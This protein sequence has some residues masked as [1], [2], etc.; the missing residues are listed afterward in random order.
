MN[1]IPAYYQEFCEKIAVDVRWVQAF[2]TSPEYVSFKIPK[3]RGGYRT[4]LKPNAQLLQVQKRLVKYLTSFYKPPQAVHGFVAE[5]NIVSNASA[6]LGCRVLLNIDLE[7]YFGSVKSR[8]LGVIFQK[9][10]FRFSQKLTQLI[11]QLTFYG[12]SLPQGAPTSPLLANLASTRLDEDLSHYAQ[13]VGATYTRYADDIT[14]S[15]ASYVMPD[16]IAARVKG[17]TILAPALVS[18]IETHGFKINDD[19]VR[20][21]TRAERKEV[22]GLTVTSRL[23]VSRRYLN[24]VRA[25]LHSLKCDG[26]DVA[27]YKH[28]KHRS[29][30]RRTPT[31]FE[32]VLHGKIEY[33]GMVRGRD[34][35]LY[36][37]LKSQ[38]AALC[39]TVKPS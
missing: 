14:F 22:T 20:L 1:T 12:G 13:Q 11:L 25:M 4:I 36:L 26:P 2:V 27:L 10:P 34:D 38:L 6:H 15:T 18:L 33:I 3:R 28:L 29:S 9:E 23:N 21:R 39:R 37:S 17:K 19:K 8:T 24:Q 30:A 5:R 7:D 32:Q 35:A 16:N 31:S